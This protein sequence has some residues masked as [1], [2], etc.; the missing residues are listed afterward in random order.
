MIPEGGSNALGVK[1]CGEILDLIP[2]Q[3]SGKN[4][5]VAL[6]CGTGATL[7]GLILKA[8]ETRVGNLE[9]LGISVLKEDGYLQKEVEK[10]LRAS[11]L[12][13][14]LSTIPWQMIDRFHGGGYARSTN[15]LNHFLEEWRELSE[16]PIE[17]VYSGKLFWGLR[18]MIEAGEIP[19]GSEL[20][21]IHTGGVY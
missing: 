13:E 4:R 6:A 9:L 5:F 10:N 19:K 8:I 12:E 16:I 3:E 18:E 11:A 20:I 14:Q 21:A 2:T 1:G 15:K 7:S 17:P